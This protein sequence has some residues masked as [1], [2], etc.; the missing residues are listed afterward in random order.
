VRL[1]LIA[2]ASTILLLPPGITAILIRAAWK[3]IGRRAR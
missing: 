2:A 3:L 1:V